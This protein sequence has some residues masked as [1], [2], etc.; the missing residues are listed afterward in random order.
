MKKMQ[1]PFQRRGN[2]IFICAALCFGTVLASSAQ[3]LPP[4]PPTAVPTTAPLAA[5]PVTE[6]PSP[7]H[8]AEVTFADGLLTVRANDSSLHQILRSISRHTGMK[9]TGGIADLRVFGDYGPAAP[10]TVLA[11]L[12][13]GTG[14]NMLLLEGSGAPLEL[15]LTPRTGGASP[16]NF[17]ASLQDADSEPQPSQPGRYSVPPPLP[18]NRV[19]QSS[20]S[21]RQ[22]A[23]DLQQSGTGSVPPSM[24]Q[25]LNNVLGS[26]N[27][28]TPTASQLPTTNSVPLDSLPTPSTAVSGPGIVDSTNPPPAGSTTAPATSTDAASPNGVKTPEQ[29]FQ[30]LLQMQKQQQ[31]KPQQ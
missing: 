6:A 12:T 28:T 31:S 15:V 2:P 11:T 7:V 18:R 22:A 3:S 16:P 1:S 21:E 29:I 30:Q 14:V 8:R 25:P 23:Q 19:P 5:T 24:P 10:A 9:I 4:T 20:P 17:D 27:N 26:E 13:D